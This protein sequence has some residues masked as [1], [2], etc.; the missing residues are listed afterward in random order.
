MTLLETIRLKQKK[1]LA[2]WDQLWG[3]I[4]S[5]LKT[6]SSKIPCILTSAKTQSCLLCKI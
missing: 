3:N 6:H 2:L 1:L 4:Q 5:S